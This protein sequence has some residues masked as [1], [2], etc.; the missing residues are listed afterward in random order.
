ML[1][2]TL[3]WNACMKHSGLGS[4]LQ[5]MFW[6]M[7][8][9]YKAHF[10]S[11]SEICLLS[12]N[13]LALYWADAE[14]EAAGLPGVAAG[15]GRKNLA[16]LLYLLS[17]DAVMTIPSPNQTACLSAPESSATDRGDVKVAAGSLVVTCPSHEGLCYGGKKNRFSQLDCQG[18]ERYLCVLSR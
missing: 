5:W 14:A 11:G 10:V 17:S 7:P 9:G 3:V 6:L 16:T 15:L 8:T 1:V 12:S 18:L 2:W 4:L 13:S